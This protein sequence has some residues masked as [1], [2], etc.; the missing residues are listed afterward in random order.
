MA[1]T[2]EVLVGYGQVFGPPELQR[3]CD[4]VVDHVDPDGTRP[5]DAIHADRRALHLT[6]CRD[7]M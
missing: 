2:E 7:G 3:V 5:R 4:R 6:R 1:E